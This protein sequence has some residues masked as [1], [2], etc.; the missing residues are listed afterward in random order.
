MRKR[1]ALA[2]LTIVVWAGVGGA[3]EKVFTFAGLRWGASRREVAS[4]LETKGYQNVH[5]DDDG[6]VVFQ[7]KWLSYRTV[8]VGLIGRDG[9]AKVTYVIVTP[10]DEAFEMY[11]TVREELTRK[12]GPP[13]IDVRDFTWP[14]YE[15]DGYEG[16]A[17]R[18]GMAKLVCAWLTGEDASD[19][20]VM[21]DVD[22]DNVVVRLMYESKEWS[23]EADR[24]KRE[25]SA[26][27]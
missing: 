9:L 3:E 10:D 4:V 15:G 17:I 8:G 25:A 20:G 1:V 2:I 13:D 27:F 26:D 22:S 11:D 23:R 7:G 5:V 21:I 16:Q 14:Y 19:G 24:R 18:T 12:Y 6:D